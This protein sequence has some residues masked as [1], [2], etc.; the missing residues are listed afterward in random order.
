MT[1]DG[2]TWFA[3][4]LERLGADVGQDLTPGPHGV[5]AV[6]LDGVGIALESPPHAA[7]VYLHGEV[8]RIARDRAGE[9]EAALRRNLFGLP[10]SNAWLALD[11]EGDA[12]L[13]CCAAPRRDLDPDS[14]SALIEAFALSIRELRRPAAP[15]AR[16]D[17]AVAMEGLVLRV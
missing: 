10:L 4:L 11:A 6:E 3:D 9:I 5:V 1:T 12:L 16:A 7:F 14:L 13:L 17:G 15:T 8:R 2:E